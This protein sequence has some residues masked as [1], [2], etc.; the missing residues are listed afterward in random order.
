MQVAGVHGDDEL[1]VVERLEGGR[2]IGEES[3]PPGAALASGDGT[4]DRRRQLEQLGPLVDPQAT[5]LL[6]P[7]VDGLGH[8]AG[9]RGRLPGGGSRPF[10]DPLPASSVVALGG[11]G[12]NECLHGSRQAALRAER[13]EAW[14]GT[15]RRFPHDPTQRGLLQHRCER[16]SC[17]RPPARGSGR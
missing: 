2:D 16:R 5:E 7:P 11:S 12:G 8:R 10:L 14:G 3:I 4:G 17:R 6:D 1:G 13:D 15:E 9:Q